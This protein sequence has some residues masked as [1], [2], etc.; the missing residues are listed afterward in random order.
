MQVNIPSA[1]FSV[2]FIPTFRYGKWASR[3]QYFTLKPAG[4][5]DITR[6]CR[7]EAGRLFQSGT[8]L[9]SDDGW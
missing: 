4:Q 8:S 3:E 7:L 2:S 5:M 1:D 6:V 9:D